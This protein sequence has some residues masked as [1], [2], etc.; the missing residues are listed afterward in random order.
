[1]LETRKTLITD[2]KHFAKRGKSQANSDIT[3]FHWKVMDINRCDGRVRLRDLEL[4]DIIDPQNFVPEDG[5]TI[6]G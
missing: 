3:G 4:V 5:V 6:F 2:V 1:L